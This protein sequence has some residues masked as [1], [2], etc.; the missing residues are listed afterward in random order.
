MLSIGQKVK[1]VRLN[2]NDFA[3]KRFLYKTGTV[4]RREFGTSTWPCGDSPTD[5]LYVVQTSIGTD[6]FW[7]EELQPVLP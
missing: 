1:I 7:T 4:V 3:D 2:K 5:P 6:A